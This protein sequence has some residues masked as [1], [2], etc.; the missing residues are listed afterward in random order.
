MIGLPIKVVA[1]VCACEIAT[2]SYDGC[3]EDD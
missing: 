2:A 1:F 3:R